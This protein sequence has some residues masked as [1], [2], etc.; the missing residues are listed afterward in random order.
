MNAKD[1]F[2][3][4]FCVGRQQRRFKCPLPY[5]PADVVEKAVEQ[6]YA[7]IRLPEDVQEAIRDGLR[8]EIERQRA[9]AEPEIAYARKRVAELELE[10]RRLVRGTITGAVPDDLAREEQERIAAEVK[11]A[12]RV[13]ATAEVVYEHIEDTLNRALELVGRCDEVYRLGGRRCGGDLTSSS[14][15]GCSS[16]PRR[17]GRRWPALCSTSRGPRSGPRTSSGRWGKTDRTPPKIVLVEVR[18]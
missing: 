8:A 16:P 3:Y 1:K 7:T 9:Q 18:K 4:F 5:L 13:L 14:S 2:M 10:R 6:Y 15:T 17:T 12:E 11:Q